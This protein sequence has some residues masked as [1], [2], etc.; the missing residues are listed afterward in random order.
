MTPRLYAP[1]G[2]PKGTTATRK[3]VAAH[4]EAY[5]TRHGTVFHSTSSCELL[6]MG[7][8]M[9]TAGGRH[10]YPLEAKNVSEMGRRKPCSR[11]W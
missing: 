2:R 11:C 4:E 7:Q 1:R 9:N 10:N 8:N 3:L 5:A 6:R